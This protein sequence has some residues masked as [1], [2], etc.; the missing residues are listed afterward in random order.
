MP[1]Y[2]SSKAL[3]LD[4]QRQLE[5]ADHEKLLSICQQFY[6]DD[7]A[8]YGVYPFNELTGPAQICEQL[9]QPLTQSFTALQRRPVIFIAGA[10]Q[11]DGGHWVTSFGHFMGVLDKPWLGIPSTGR[12]TMLRYAEFYLVR[13]NKIVET[14]FFCDIINVMRQ[15]G[16]NPLPPQTGAAITWPGPKTQDGLLLKDADPTESA[17]TIDLVNRMVDDLDVLNKSGDDNCPP[18]YLAKTWHDSMVWYG[19]DGIGSSYTIPVYQ[20][21]HQYPF[22]EGLADKVFNGHVCRYAEG[23]YAC[24][25][26]WPNLTNRPIGSFLGLPAGAKGADMR[27]VDM[28]RREGDKL[29]ENWVIIDLPWWLKQQGLDI[30]ERM[31]KVMPASRF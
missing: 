3:V 16:Y 7:C 15:A 28:Y 6:A 22:R 27:I 21:H 4:F 20:Q 11:Q 1:D 24:F 17:I 25:F 9:W 10:P 19:P 2:Q 13:D 31:A 14:A 30:F 26:G 5:H 8:F 23:D 29:A 18:E 12:L